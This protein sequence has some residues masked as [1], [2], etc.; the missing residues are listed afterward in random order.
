MA[1]T[2]TEKPRDQLED[3]WFHLPQCMDCGRKIPVTMKNFTVKS[4]I[5]LGTAVV[6]PICASKPGIRL[7]TPYI[8]YDGLEEIRKMGGD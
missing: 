1:R 4:A 3:E 2:K 8:S 6:C 7:K 5:G